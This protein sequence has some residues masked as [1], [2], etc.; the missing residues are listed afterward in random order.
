MIGK[1]SLEVGD[2]ARQLHI[3]LRLSLALPNV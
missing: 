2:I 3:D 1:A